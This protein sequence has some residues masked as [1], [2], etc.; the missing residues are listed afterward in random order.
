[1]RVCLLVHALTPHEVT[2]VENHTA[3]LAAALARLGLEVQVLA[4]CPLKGTWRLAQRQEQR[5]GYEIHWLALGERQPDEEGNE[6]GVAEAFGRYLDRERPGLVHAQHLIGLGPALVT[7]ARRRGIPFLFTAH[8]AW[9]VSEEYRLL[10]PDFVALEPSDTEAQARVLLARRL[11]DRL[12]PEADHQGL[13]TPGE[14]D[15][16]GSA[17]RSEVLDGDP[18]AAGF[19]PEEIEG[20]RRRAEISRRAR[21]EALRGVELVIS[22]TEFLAGVLR[23]GGVEAPLVVEACGI[24][25]APFGRSTMVVRLQDEPLRVAFLGGVSKHKGLHDLLEAVDGLAGVQLSVHGGSSD[26]AYFER[27]RERAQEVGAEWSGAFEASELPAILSTTDILVVPSKWPENA[28]FVIREAFAA[29]VPVIAADVGAMS[30]SLRHGVDGWLF[31]AGDVRALRALLEELA[32][33]PAKLEEVKRGV[34][35]PRSIDEQ[36][37]SL[38][39][40]YEG[41]FGGGEERPR[42]RLEHLEDFTRRYEAVEDSG[43]R[44]LV[45]GS[46]AGYRRLCEALSSKSS[47]G[48]RIMRAIARGAKLRERLAEGERA[49]VWLGDILD[50]TRRKGEAEHA[51]AEWQAAGRGALFEKTA[52][53]EEQLAARTE[54]VAALRAGGERGAAEREQLREER[55]AVSTDLELAGAEASWL[56]GQLEFARGEARRMEGE[57]D[58]RAGSL[59]ERTREAEW[60]KRELADRDQRLAH[61]A[62]KL[63]DAQRARAAADGEREQQRTIAGRAR[64][65]SVWREGVVEAKERELGAQREQVAG[66]IEARAHFEK[67]VSWLRETHEALRGEIAFL[68]GEVGAREEERGRWREQMERLSTQQERL[69]EHELWLRGELRRL[70]EA[71]TGGEGEELAPE[72]V[73][74]SVSAAV[75]ALAADELDGEE[76]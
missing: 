16:E 8:D 26:H 29:G 34:R 9:L 18:K 75:E 22:P 59:E 19:A 63:E 1:M 46:L 36:A 47:S 44:E 53:L 45:E 48:E 31:P 54:E 51:R 40:R 3:Q 65:E 28:P 6:P 39:E 52:W 11:L 56:E 17:L 23:R 4:P 7:E 5:D 35:A 76:D 61:A 2:G 50:E 57:R 66:L 71:V 33:S 38:L 13:V 14:L 60:L 74:G 67:E 58:R 70:L 62:R 30:E 68:R 25:L 64:E 72:D 42:A 43:W 73:A 20:M 12:L 69:L 21:L 15:P 10:R 24:D 49:R 27:C 41:C 32:D 37:A 55:A